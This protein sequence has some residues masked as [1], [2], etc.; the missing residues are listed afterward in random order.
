MA[1]AIPGKLYG[2]RWNDIYLECQ[3]EADFNITFNEEEQEPCKPNP[4]EDYKEFGYTT[5][6]TVSATW[7]V[8]G[9][10][11]ATDSDQNNQNSLMSDL[12][13]G[14]NRGDVELFTFDGNN[15]PLDFQ[16]VVSGEAKITDFALSGPQSGDATYTLTINGQGEFA[17]ATVP[18]TT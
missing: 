13:S 18:V 9:T 4:D 16:T 3:T 11:R 14:N 5:S 2:I 6:N 12:A 17:V 7:S 1:N 15:S 10:F 8:S